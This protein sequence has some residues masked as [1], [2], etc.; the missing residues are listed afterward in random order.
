AS[1]VCHKVVELFAEDSDCSCYRPSSGISE[2][3]E[4]STI[5]LTADI[6]KEFNITRSSLTFYDSIQHLEHPLCSFAAW[7]AFSARF[8]HVE[9]SGSPDESDNTGVFVKEHTTT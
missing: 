1:T 8:V 5:N 7:C 4:A 6:E 9:L 2:T 3:T